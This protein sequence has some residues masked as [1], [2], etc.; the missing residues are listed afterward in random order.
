MVFYYKG[1]ANE[2]GVSLA[3]NTIVALDV[4]EATTMDRTNAI[5]LC[6][7]LNT[8]KEALNKKGYSEFEIEITG[9]S[10]FDEAAKYAVS[11]INHK[12]M[13]YAIGIMDKIRCPLYMVG[14]STKEEIKQY[15]NE[16]GA[17]HNQEEG[18]YEKY[19]DEEEALFKG[20]DLL[21]KERKMK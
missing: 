19:G 1:T 6:E 15:L 18:W 9:L 20:Y 2:S 12:E 5:K 11:K 7:S 8:D 4:S 3:L 16:W 14:N 17:E 21:N 10:P 13:Y